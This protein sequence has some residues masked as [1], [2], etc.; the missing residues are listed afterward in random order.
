MDREGTPANAEYPWRDGQEIK[1]PCRYSYPNLYFLTTANPEG[2]EFLQIVQ[3][4]IEEFNGKQIMETEGN[5]E[6]KDKSQE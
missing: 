5:I 2:I 6:L 4:A 1:I 3:S